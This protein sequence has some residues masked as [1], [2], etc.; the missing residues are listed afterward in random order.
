MFLFLL[1]Q[2]VADPT[3][4][5]AVAIS[6][7]PDYIMPML[8]G[9]LS[10]AGGYLFKTVIERP[11]QKVEQFEEAKYRGLQEGLE[12]KHR[13]LE[14]SLN[15]FKS[16][17]QS[18]LRDWQHWREHQSERTTKLELQVENITKQLSE[19]IERLEDGVS[20][21]KEITQD[22]REQLAGLKVQLSETIGKWTK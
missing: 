18:N 21:T 6:S 16:T 19:K 11:N 17:N 15:E 20:E 9:I 22:I 14:N 3:K 7:S 2:H 8:V 4:P 12:A 5:S 10:A 13:A 1:L